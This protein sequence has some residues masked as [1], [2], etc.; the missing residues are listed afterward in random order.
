MTPAELIFVKRMLPHFE[1]GLS[2]VDAA[3]A[4]LADDER[5]MNDVFANSRRGVEDG[6]RTELASRIYHACRK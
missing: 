2:V 6:V 1:A 3:K 4:V 5:I